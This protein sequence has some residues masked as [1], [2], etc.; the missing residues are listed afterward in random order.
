MQISIKKIKKRILRI[1]EENQDKKKM[2]ANISRKT[3]EKRRLKIS[4]ENKDKE[5]KMISNFN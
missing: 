1:S 2:I 3:I 5:K 4:E